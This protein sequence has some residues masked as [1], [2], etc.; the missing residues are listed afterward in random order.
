M[1][2]NLFLGEVVQIELLKQKLL[3]IRT[4]KHKRYIRREGIYRGFRKKEEEEKTCIQSFFVFVK[5]LYIK[6]GRTHEKLGKNYPHLWN[7]TKHRDPSLS[8]NSFSFK[9]SDRI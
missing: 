8:S 6:C 4:T 1:F 5:L 7:L 2:V 3:K 9:R